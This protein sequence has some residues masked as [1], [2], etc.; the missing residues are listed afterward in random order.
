MVRCVLTDA[1]AAAVR[2][3]LAHC[4]ARVAPTG[5]INGLAQLVLKSTLPG[6]PDYYQGCE[7]WE[8]GPTRVAPG[9]PGVICERPLVNADR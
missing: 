2:T 8:R 6:V 1:R 4:V 3:D 9:G 5:Y 7:F